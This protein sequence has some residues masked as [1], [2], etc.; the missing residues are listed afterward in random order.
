MSH[1]DF[2]TSDFYSYECLLSNEERDLLHAVRKFTTTDVT[3]LLLEH[4]S[5]ATFPFEIVP[6]MRELGLAGLPYDGYG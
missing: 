4:W 2:D 6:G 5:R 3:P 1:N